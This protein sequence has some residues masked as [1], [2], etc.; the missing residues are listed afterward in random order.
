[1]AEPALNPLT[2][3]PRRMSILLPRL[4]PIWLAT[5]GLSLAAASAD[6]QD[7]AEDK[8]IKIANPNVYRWVFGGDSDA[9][10]AGKVLEK[11]LR[12]KVEIVDRACRLTAVQKEKLLLA[13][14]GDIK[15]FTD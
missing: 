9:I 6:D 11:T 4:L 13:G 2:N 1:M 5:I 15:R 10:A 3:E 12:Q 8:Q 7:I 14:R